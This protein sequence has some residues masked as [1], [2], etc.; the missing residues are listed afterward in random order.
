MKALDKIAKHFLK[1]VAPL[2]MLVVTMSLTGCPG[3]DGGTRVG[4]PI[5]GSVHTC[6][7]VCPVNADSL[8]RSAF[9][10]EGYGGSL[11]SQLTL[12]ILGD[13]VYGNGYYTGNIY[14]AGSFQVFQQ[15]YYG[16]P[17]YTGRYNI[18]TVQAGSMNQYGIF[19][20]VQVV[21]RGVEGPA[22]GHAIDMVVTSM[23]TGAFN[24]KKY[25]AVGLAY[26]FGLSGDVAIRSVDGLS[27]NGMGLFFGYQK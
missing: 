23:S 27:C 11:K 25:N 8:I 2:S 9:G 5:T 15:S 4:T 13:Q 18:E 10:D 24:G 26:D 20:N 14:L 7:G 3:E 17:I 22:A 12:D 1:V 6:Q 19:G 16:C 21:A